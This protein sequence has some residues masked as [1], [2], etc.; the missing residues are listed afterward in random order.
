MIQEKQKY[1]V[2]HKTVS[3]LLSNFQQGDILIPEIQRP[4]VWKATQVRDLIDSLY[5]GYPIGYIVT[6]RSSNVRLKNGQRSGGETMIIDG[7]Q[8]ITALATALLGVETTDADY[9]KRVIKIAFSPKTK[10]FVVPDASTIKDKSY[11]NDISIFF[12]DDVRMARIRRKYM[13][14]N[15]D[16]DEDELADILD[17]VASLKGREIGLLE[18]SKNLEMDTVTEIFRRI[19]QE[20]TLLKEADFVMSKIAANEAH[21]GNML[22]KVIDH[23]S[24]LVTKPER[25]EAIATNDR[26]FATSS[27]LNK[28]SW[29]K[30]EN[31]DIYDPSYEDIVR[32]VLTYKF[33]RGKMGQ[34]VQ[35][36]DGRNFTTRTDEAAIIDDTYQ[37]LTDGIIDF[38]KE[39]N[40]KKFVMVVSS[41]GFCR[42]RIIR[43]M[44][45][46][47]FCYALY[48]HLYK[49]EYPQAKLQ[50]VVRRWLVMALLTGR[51]SSGAETRYE[52]DINQITE[53]GI[54][55]YLTQI[56]QVELSEVF[57]NEKLVNNLRTSGTT[58]A[59]Y[60][61]FLAAQC[62]ANAKGFLST[63][64]TVRNM[65]EEK[66]DVHHIFPRQFL[67][68]RGFSQTLY[69]QVANY[70]Y[71]QTE[72]N[73][74]ISDKAPNDYF[75]YV[76][77]DQCCGQPT[78]Y[79]GIV[80]LD[81][82]KSNMAENCIPEGLE[83]MTEADYADFCAKRRL[84]MAEN[85]RNYYYSL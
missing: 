71:V 50:S 17:S 11:I 85:I 29:L 25:Y 40:F 47:N 52:T 31:D 22:R 60:N 14:D 82:L 46:M 10:K 83:S 30:N 18:L 63:D 76:V 5:K 33:K 66:G 13:E 2:G 57:W 27:Y 51:Y 35:L 68:E 20:G 3:Q 48:L 72:I 16:M 61:V 79:G 23:F 36:L 42:G 54:D 32:V 74:A 19:N 1:E 67:K 77:N 73:Q 70:A 6:S 69:N 26:E 65:I 81:T 9:N 7:Q 75:A 56:E 4:F 21:G 62:K 37:K 78:K 34:L 45:T 55:E 15:P 24:E 38:I 12:K 49:T 84:F 43:S 28:I 53:L 39:N 44:G 8:R 41:A 58:S 64:I 59:A 80:S